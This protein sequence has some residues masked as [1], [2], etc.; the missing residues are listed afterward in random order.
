MLIWII[1]RFLF[2]IPLLVKLFDKLYSLTNLLVVQPENLKQVCSEEQLVCLY[3]HAVMHTSARALFVFALTLFAT[4]VI[5]LLSNLFILKTSQHLFNSWRCRIFEIAYSKRKTISK[6]K[7]FWVRE[8]GE[9]EVNYFIP[10]HRK[11][12]GRHNQGDIRASDDGKVGCYTVEYTTAFLYSDFPWHD[13]NSI[14]Y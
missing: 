10:S 13:I 3:A 14:R 4:L 12:S 1:L 5:I 11:C 2:Q 8:S 7:W 6:G 9:F